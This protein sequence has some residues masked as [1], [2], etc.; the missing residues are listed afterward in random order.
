MS[1]NGSRGE[2]THCN[3]K[4]EVQISLPIKGHIHEILHQFRRSCGLWGCLNVDNIQELWWSISNSSMA[5]LKQQSWN[6][7]LLNLKC[8]AKGKY[9]F[10]MISFLLAMESQF[11]FQDN[12]VSSKHFGK[13]Q[14]TTT[15]T[16]RNSNPPA[17][18]LQEKREI[19]RSLG[20]F[21]PDQFA[22]ATL[23]RRSK[24][25]IKVAQSSFHV[26]CCH[27]NKQSGFDLL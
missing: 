11:L 8:W 1:E 18:H 27:R 5:H 23:G 25:Q 20:N 9:D 3:C 12:F 15:T 16:R 2:I 4:L 21:P 19:E 22:W 24:V 26:F 10:P 6:F 13:I 17:D 7:L 14:T